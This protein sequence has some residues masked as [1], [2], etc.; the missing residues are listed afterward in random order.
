MAYA[1]TNLSGG[2]GGGSNAPKFYTFRDTGS[3]K[4]AMDVDDYFLD[5]NDILKVGDG[6]FATGSDG[7]VLFGVTAVSATTVT[8]EEATLV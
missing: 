8:V 6:I 1:R 3:T 5:L 4:A 2:I 7:S